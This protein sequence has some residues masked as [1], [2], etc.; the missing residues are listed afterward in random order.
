MRVNTLQVEGIEKGKKTRAQKF[1]RV[2]Y[3]GSLPVSGIRVKTVWKARGRVS[4]GQIHRSRSCRFSCRLSIFSHLFNLSLLLP[5]D[6]LG[7]VCTLLC[8]DCYCC[9]IIL[10]PFHHPET[11]PLRLLVVD[12]FDSLFRSFLYFFLKMVGFTIYFH[13][14][15]FSAAYRKVDTFADELQQKKA[16]RRCNGSYSYQ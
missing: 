11:S 6:I 13:L 2:G 12:S 3:F 15:F 4:S 10:Q 16:C 7:C 8:L 14:G 5:S 9:A 1:I